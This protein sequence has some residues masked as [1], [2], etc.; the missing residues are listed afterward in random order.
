MKVRVHYPYPTN[1]K[2][3]VTIVVPRR[4]QQDIEVTLESGADKY[5][6]FKLVV[7]PSRAVNPPFGQ[8]N[9]V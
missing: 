9:P 8:H 2:P 4:G 1:G 5:D 3:A 7:T 6:T